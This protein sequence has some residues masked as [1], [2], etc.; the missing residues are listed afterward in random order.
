M[1]IT[2]LGAR[3]SVPTAGKN[4]QEFGGST[5]CILVETDEYAIF[6]DAGTGILNTPDL[7]NRKIVILLSHP[8]IDHLI[9]LPF[10]PVNREKGRKVDI[11][12]KRRGAYGAAEQIER[13]ISPPLWPC[14]L[15]DYPADFEVHD[16]MLPLKLGDI[17]ITAMESEHPGGSLIYR[18]SQNG[19]SFVYATD[20]EHY[21]ASIES[22]EN[23]VRDTD[24]LFYDGQYTPEEAERMRG[25][26]HS[27]VE[28]GM[29]VMKEANVS[30]MCFV[31]HDPRHSDEML[32]KME[33][34]V[35][36]ENVWFAREGQVITL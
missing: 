17:E 1:K 35:R 8:H 7:G 24:L 26:G 11:Y 12:A 19:K 30:K 16:L 15:S 10:F 36:S 28:A 5:S 25:F 4:M 13:L 32:I 22:L 29:R 6:L 2:I 31:H 3:G 9:G 21:E 23:F 33:D 18:I 20:Y 27:T 14:I 34:A